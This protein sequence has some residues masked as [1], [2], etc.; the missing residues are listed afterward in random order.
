MN[1]T[2]LRLPDAASIQA[3]LA[4]LD[5]ASADTDRVLALAAAFPGFDFNLVHL[6]DEYWRDTRS[7][8]RPDR[9]RRRAA[10]TDDGRTH[11]GRRRYQGHLRLCSDRRSTADYIQIALGREI[12]WRA[13]SIV[14]PNYR[15]WGEDEL[16]DPGWP[17]RADIQ[18]GPVFRAIDRSEAIEEAGPAGPSAESP[19]AYRAPR[20]AGIRRRARGF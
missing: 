13:G 8:I 16:L 3:T 18:K 5:S 11:Q 15:P 17:K 7:V 19:K 20:R 10:A 6:D 2:P 9:A 4:G 12:T 14:N 1:V